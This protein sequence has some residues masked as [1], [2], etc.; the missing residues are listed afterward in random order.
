MMPVRRPRVA[1]AV[2][3]ACALPV[4]GGAQS[5]AAP[6]VARLVANLQ[7]HYDRIAD[8][9]ADFEHHYAGG[10]LRTTDVER[11]TMH[12]K[13]PRRWRFD[14]VD[15]EPKLF[16]CDGTTIHSWFPADRQVIVSPLPAGAG[17][18]TSAALLAGEGDLLRDFTAR[19]AAG[20]PPD[21]AWSIELRPVAGDAGYESVILTVDRT[22]LDVL[23]IA[24]TDFQGGVST[25][26]LSNVMQNQGLSDTLF[27]FDVPPD[28]EVIR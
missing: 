14:Y 7:A 9:S 6:P 1:F 23:E 18:S 17:A 24:T 3:V 15:P 19:Y 27:G 22:T 5:P 2:L 25:Y 11:G 28:V 8:L 20:P 10:V 16:V 4:A 26:V 12:V 21:G 13:K